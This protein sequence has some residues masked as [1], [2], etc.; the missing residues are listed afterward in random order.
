MNRNSI[1]AGERPEKIEMTLR[2]VT[3]RY[4]TLRDLILSRMIAFYEIKNH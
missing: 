1:D 3:L 4:V 2:Y